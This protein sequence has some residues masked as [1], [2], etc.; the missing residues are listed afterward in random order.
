[1]IYFYKTKPCFFAQSA[2]CN[3]N[4][5]SVECVFF[6]R[7]YTEHQVTQVEVCVKTTLPDDSVNNVPCFIT[8]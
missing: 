6:T 8:V 1:M 3:G 5:Y 7:T 4:S 2:V